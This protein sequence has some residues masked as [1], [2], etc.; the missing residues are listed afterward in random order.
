[1]ES[2]L[3]QKTYFKKFMKPG[4]ELQPVEVLGEVFRGI[5]RKESSTE[6]SSIRFAQGEIYFHANDMEAAIYKWEKI[7]SELEPWAKKNIADAYV[8]LGMHV[9]AEKLYIKIQSP[10]NVLAVE[11]ALKLFFLHRDREKIDKAYKYMKKAISIDP[12]YHDVTETARIFYEQQKDYKSAVELAVSE[13]IRTANPLWFRVIKKYVDQGYTKGY[14]PDYFYEALQI[15]STVDKTLFAEL[16]TA[17]WDSYKHGEYYLTWLNNVN[18]LLVT[19]EE[20]LAAWDNL[21]DLFRESY[22]DILDGRYLVKDVQPIIPSMLKN[23]LTFSKEKK[24]LFPAAA[25]F[26]W[27]EVFPSRIDASTL[28]L[29]NNYILQSEYES[30]KLEDS[31]QLLET[32]YTWAEINNMKIDKKAKWLSSKL[33]EGTKNHLYVTGLMGSGVQDVQSF[34]LDGKGASESHTSFVELGDR[35]LQEVSSEGIKQV[36][37][38]S[39]LEESAIV[40]QKENSWFLRQLECSLI[41]VPEC[42]RFEE[43]RYVDVA[44]GVLFVVK[45]LSDESVSLIRRLRKEFLVPVHF[46]LSVDDDDWEESEGKLRRCFPESKVYLHFTR[47]KR[48]RDFVMFIEDSF[49]F[50][51][52]SEEIQASKLLHVIRATLNDLLSRREAREVALHKS[53]EFYDDILRKLN[54]FIGNVE[55][56][57]QEK[58]EMVVDTYSSIKEDAKNQAMMAIPKLLR[59]CSSFIQEDSDFSNLH[60][61]LNRKMND[62]V[63]S[64]FQ[65]ELIPEFRRDLE[66]WLAATNEDLVSYQQYLTEM[67]ETLPVFAEKRMMLTCD[68]QVLN[69]WRRDI[70]RKT[71]GIELVEENIMNRSHAS[72]FFLK[73]AGKLFGSRQKNNSMLYQRYKKFVDNQSFDEVARSIIEKYFFEFDSFER[74]LKGDV[75]IFFEDVKRELEKHVEFCSVEKE[76]AQ[77]QVEGMHQNP[78]IFYDPLKLFEVRLMQCETMERAKKSD[79]AVK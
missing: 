7:D 14:I 19:G 69:D 62:E 46:V 13:A 29:A 35:L 56:A 52:V 21:S 71:K 15:V 60:E 5:Q 64:F 22:L 68:M 10:S 50:G 47:E 9:E 38:S 67:C 63:Y 74:V 30:V 33:L 76:N 16:A 78:E 54:G 11:V 24:Y 58:L 39:E 18:V 34:L 28:E 41:F 53:I 51:E 31:M 42:D 73:S 49:A 57:E 70:K 44:D 32:L 72:Q 2:Q 20:H 8:E 59:D 26:A 23:W 55:E 61:E 37:E 66:D 36:E 6:L 25:V 27:N 12:D 65:E 77:E 45:E 43:L 75:G 79:V 1:M 40:F 17:F 3:V 48:L 4:V